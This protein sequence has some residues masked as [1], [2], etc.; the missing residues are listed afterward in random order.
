MW[1]L[2]IRFA[3]ADAFVAVKII[4]CDALKC[5]ISGIREFVKA[6]AS[7]TTQKAYYLQGS[8]SIITGG[9]LN[10]QKG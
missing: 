8:C 7:E 5:H 1:Y 9:R 3:Y 6:D 10:N 2:H 4:I